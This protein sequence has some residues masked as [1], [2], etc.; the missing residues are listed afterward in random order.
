MKISLLTFL[1]E[2]DEGVEPR[3]VRGGRSITP[4]DITERKQPLAEKTACDKPSKCLCNL[5]I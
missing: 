2:Y 5:F 3:N 4:L 1:V